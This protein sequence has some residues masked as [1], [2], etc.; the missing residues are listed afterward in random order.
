MSGV[1]FTA[2]IKGTLQ[3]GK[4]IFNS[5]NFDLFK[6]VFYNSKT[7]VINAHTYENYEKQVN[8]ICAR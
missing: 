8:K 1:P 5:M 6:T 4:E 7:E 2:L 3:I